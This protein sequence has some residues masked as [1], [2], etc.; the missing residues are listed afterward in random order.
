MAKHIQAYFTEKNDAESAAT[1]LKALGAAQVQTD[2][3]AVFE[4][5]TDDA[6]SILPMVPQNQGAFVGAP[7]SQ[8]PSA[9]LFAGFD[10]ARDVRS[11]DVDADVSGAG[12][13]MLMAVIED[14]LYDKAV[15][16]VKQ[17]GGRVE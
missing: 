10:D 16:I 4:H 14:G 5:F 13:P 3:S 15:G 8:Q 9:V 12:Q 6:R 2:R 1:S 7:Y 17:H 11:K